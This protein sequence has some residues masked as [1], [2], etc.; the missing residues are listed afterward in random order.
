[1]V[2]SDI[3]GLL[4]VYGYVAILL[5]VSEKV[6]HRYPNFSRKFLHIMPSVC[7]LNISSLELSSGGGTRIIS[8]NLPG[9]SSAESS[10]SGLLVAPRTTTPF[11]SSNP[12][13]SESSVF[14]IRSTT[15]GSP[16]PVPLIAARASSSSKNT[17]HEY[18]EKVLKG[19][20]WI[21]M[22]SIE[23]CRK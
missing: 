21:D 5:L 15:R 16:I 12:S 6:L 14:T 3:I 13:I 19:C 10:K 18:P 9:R 23:D 22:Y 8:S 11:S 20:H 17:M 2:A 1:M 4:F 7:T